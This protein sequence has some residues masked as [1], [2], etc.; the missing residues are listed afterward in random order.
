VKQAGLSGFAAR[1]AL[2][3]LVVMLAVPSTAVARAVT[4]PVGTPLV[5]KFEETLNPA[6]ASVGT[7]VHLSVLTDITIDG[8]VV[9]SAGAPATGQVTESEKPGSI[10]KPAVL[11]VT[12]QSAEAID[13]TLVPI[14]G[15]TVVEGENKQTTTLIITILCCVLGLLMKGGDVDIPA[16]TTMD[17]TVE[18]ATD[19]TV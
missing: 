3:I 6:T 18:L 14:S 12:L 11:G 5:L 4:I 19:I 1:W 7:T 15:M 13:G 8:R 2:V 16:G 10:G 9:F 17:G